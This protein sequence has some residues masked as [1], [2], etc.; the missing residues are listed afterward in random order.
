MSEFNFPKEE[1]LTLRKEVET[2][3]TELGQL[4][5]NTVLASAAV[6]AWLA[7]D[8][9]ET[10]IAGIGWYIPILFAFFGALRSLS[11][12]FHLVHLGDYIKKIEATNLTEDKNVKGWEHHLATSKSSMRKVGTIVFW[13]VFLL[14]TI[15]IGFTSSQ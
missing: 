13:I 15:I 5:R 2:H 9:A 7:K 14:T 1:Y 6:Y 10:S 4:E 3:M 12:C 11:L 8:G